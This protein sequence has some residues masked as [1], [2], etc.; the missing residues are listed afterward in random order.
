MVGF[1][2]NIGVDEKQMGGSLDSQKLRDHVLP[3]ACDESIA[4]GHLDLQADVALLAR[5]QQLEKRT[6]VEISDLP[7]V[8]GRADDEVWRSFGSG[9]GASVL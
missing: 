2:A 7:A 3:G 9:H 6:G 4:A 1:E 8:A 5:E